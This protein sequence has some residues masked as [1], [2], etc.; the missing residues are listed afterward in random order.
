MEGD[1]PVTDI[2]NDL[3]PEER[4]EYREMLAKLH[5][6]GYRDIEEHGHLKAG[7]RIRHTGHRWSA[8]YTNGT[9]IV[10]AITEKNP[11]SWSQSWGKPDIELIALWDR[12]HLF[13]RL[14]GLAQYHVEVIDPSRWIDA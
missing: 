5:A 9:G 4:I 8:A 14:C 10:L 3:T 1:R 12:V 2:V 11:S 6:C 7:V 13:S